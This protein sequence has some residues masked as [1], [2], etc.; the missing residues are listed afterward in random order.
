[1]EKEKLFKGLSRLIDIEE[2]LVT[3]YANFDKVLVKLEED[4]E[5]DRR[6]KIQDLLSTLL[7]DSSR[8][9]DMIHEMMK[10]IG[11]SDKNEY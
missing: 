4:M 2:G 10:K 5:E 6:E 7:R 3:L 9:R 1:M 11:A 8:H